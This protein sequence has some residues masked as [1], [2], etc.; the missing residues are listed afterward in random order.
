MIP[1]PEEIG[2]WCQ[3]K[4]QILC[5][6][7]HRKPNPAIEMVSKLA[8]Q[9]EFNLKL[10]DTPARVLLQNRIDVLDEHLG[11]PLFRFPATAPT[12]IGAVEAQLGAGCPHGSPLTGQ[13]AGPHGLLCGQF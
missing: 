8:I 3:I 9:C 13:N 4:S 1:M 10:F 2:R 5:T 6:G 7:R 12:R 11:T